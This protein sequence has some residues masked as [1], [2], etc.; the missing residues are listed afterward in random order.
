MRLPRNIDKTITD[1]E[2]RYKL[3]EYLVRR[4]V[5]KPTYT[6][7]GRL[8]IGSDYV[9]HYVEKLDK[10]G[11]IKRGGKG[12]RSVVY[13]HKKLGEHQKIAKYE[14]LIKRAA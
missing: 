5:I 4:E 13:D 12:S 14:T 2:L 3:V 6:Q 1:K 9:K 8:G 7:I 10:N 11:I